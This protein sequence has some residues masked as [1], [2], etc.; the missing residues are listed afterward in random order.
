MNPNIEDSLVEAIDKNRRI[1]TKDRD[2]SVFLLGNGLVAKG[3]EYSEEAVDEYSFGVLAY[4]NGISVPK[5]HALE[6]NKIG[7]YNSFVIMDYIPGKSLED[8]RGAQFRRALEL[9]VVELEKVFKLGISPADSIRYDCAIY[10]PAL[11]KI[12]IVDLALWSRYKREIEADRAFL[13]KYYRA[14]RRNKGHGNLLFMT[15]A[16]LS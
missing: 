7:K 13:E 6:H 11:D 14:A 15:R 10:N 3:Y 9:Q 8:I 12:V 16:P 2:T 1:S 4:N 5:M